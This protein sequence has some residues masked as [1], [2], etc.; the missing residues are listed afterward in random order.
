MNELGFF[1]Q[2]LIYLTSA[3]IIVP[4]AN[5]LGLGSVLGYLIAGIV[6]GPFVFGFV[7]TEG[8][9]MLHFAEFG[10]VMMLF[11]IG[12][13]LELDLLWRLKIWLLGLGGLQIILT[14]AITASFA[15]GFGFQWKSALALGLILSLSST[16][17]VLQTL[18]E[19]GLMKSVSGQAA[20]S[21]L[22]FQDMAVIPILAIFPMLSDSEVTASTQ[23]HSLIEHLPGYAKTIV[24][25]SVVVGII[26]VGKYLLSPFFRLLAKSGNREIFTGASLL[27]V[28]A[29]SVLM[30]AVGVSAA[31]GTFLGG[32]VLASSEYR[33][34]LESN[35]EPFKGLLLG[36]FFLS[37]GASMDLPIVMNSPTKI[38][39]IVF[40][41]IFIK[42]L[43][44]FLLGLV[45]RLPLDQNLYFSIA[46]SQV[47]EFSFVLFGYS[48]GLGLF[49]EESILIL[50]ACVAVSMAF[51]PVLLLLYEK[52]FFGLLESK[53]PKK[54]TEQ[55]IHKQENPVI[56]CGF[57]RFGNM[58][59]RFLR[60]NGIAITI[61]DFDA[62]RVEMLGRF[63]F[64]VYFGDPTRLELLESAGLEHARVLVAALDNPEKQKELIRN[65]SQH[66]PE[67]KIVA[68][69]GDREEAYDLKEMGVTYIYRETRETAVQMG[70]D[71]L[72]LLG[73]R[74]YTAEKAK[75]LFLKHDDETFHEL[76]A[77]RADR[78]QYMSLAK[79]RNAE[80]ERLM[81]VDLGKED[82]LERDS[83]SEMER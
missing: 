7:G 39:G 19:K 3:I 40:G 18:K 21:V 53:V 42:A 9:D 20:F 37:V 51:T 1:I 41:I 16:A 8:K 56:I 36:L 24:V 58:L 28:I 65:V 35:I 5:R 11:A 15:F 71:V 70:K 67:I 61:L 50:V 47:G 83:W 12:L 74:A 68:R 29:I 32:V 45:F 78:V 2:A 49:K 80:L 48:E 6:I 77:L 66:Y 72:K 73:T 81:L 64:K 79:Q 82:E 33:H 23:G 75:N 76:F 26:L 22:L 4:V 54:Q 57:G 25:F 62:D 43:V 59:G 17:I 60:S 69:S 30:G 10:V 46:L 52:T 55:N 38:L 44:L 34:E 63:G 13:E 14:T 27:L 31:L